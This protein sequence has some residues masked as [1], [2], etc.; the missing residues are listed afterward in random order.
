MKVWE[1]E[2]PAASFSPE[3]LTLD[4]TNY[5]FFGINVMFSASNQYILKMQIF[6]VAT[7][8]YIV[9]LAGRGSTATGGRRLSYDA[10]LHELAIQ[11]ANY[12]GNVDNTYCIPYQIYG[13]KA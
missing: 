9:D 3:T 5:D 6:P 11:Q 8:Q 13:I 10:T 4:L 2:S 12:A 1:N 7:A